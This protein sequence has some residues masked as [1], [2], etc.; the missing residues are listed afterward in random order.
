MDK[1]YYSSKHDSKPVLYSVSNND[2]RPVIIQYFALHNF[3][4]NEEVY[5]NCVAYVTWLKFHQTDQSWVIH[6]RYGT[7]MDLI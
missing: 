4:Y 2:S 5:R 7:K 3:T 1:I 6:C